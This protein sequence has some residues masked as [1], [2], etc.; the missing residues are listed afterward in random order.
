VVP[1][2]GETYEI[3]DA[4]RYGTLISDFDLQLWGEGN[5]HHAYRFMGAHTKTVDDVEGTHFVVSAPAASRVSV[6]G[7][8]NNWDGRARNE[9]I[10]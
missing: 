6:I 8:F 1:Y 5:H 7:S 2:V 10:S 4:Y 9:K 3:D